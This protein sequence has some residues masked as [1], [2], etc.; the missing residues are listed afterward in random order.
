[1]GY[2]VLIISD[3]PKLILEIEK[4]FNS[5][6][7]F[8]ILGI[9]NTSSNAYVINDF[10]PDLILFDA[11]RIDDVSTERITDLKIE[12]NSSEIPLIAIT[13]LDDRNNNLS[14]FHAGVEDFI[15][16]P[17]TKSELI[18]RV[19]IGIQR[20]HIIETLKKQAVQFSDV[21]LAANSA[22]NSIMIIDNAGSI[23]WVNGGFERL[24]E[25]KLSEFTSMFGKN[26]FDSSINKTT[27]EAM[28]RCRQSEDYV[29]YD[30]VWETP[31]GKVKSIQTTLTPIFDDSGK[32]S[33]IVVMESDITD[34]IETE[35]A[36]EEKHDHLLTL[37]EHLEEA[38]ILLDEQRNEIEAQKE[39][40]E[41]EKAKSEEL[42]RN[43]L[44]W[45]VARSLQKKGVYKPKKFKEV[46]ILF[47][48]FVD[49]S[50]ISATYDDAEALLN[51]LSCYFET[52]DEITS[53]RFIE[54]IKTIGDCYMCAGGLPRANRSHPFDILLAA[55]KMQK[56]VKDKA[57]EDEKNGRKIW[58]LRIGIHTGS[59]IAGVIGK[60]KFAYDIWGGDVNIASRLESSGEAGAINIS[61][62]TYQIIKDYFECTFRGKIHAK[63]IG[64]INMYFVE[65][66]LPE[67]SEDEQGF[68]PNAV[69]RKIVG[70]F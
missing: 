26:L 34:L 18:Q 63:N 15:N 22:G 48:D 67:Y 70:S 29:V 36:L 11:R 45:E 12:R 6:D 19:S 60:W 47:A 5:T 61:E 16:Y 2:K 14:L 30:N 54:K 41:I 62:S 24:Y 33:K 28:M 17:F 27:Y 9:N 40:V 4:L 59:V 49:F 21:S 32:F 55:L 25:C 10:L 50:R 3:A 43:I 65:R 23:V 58:R 51:V 1:M 42:L 68:T 38:N 69:L 35:R 31:S 64:D 37:T 8:L 53:T 66:I 44:P 46:T 20:G 7:D 39:S 57:V 52:F 56:F 13:S